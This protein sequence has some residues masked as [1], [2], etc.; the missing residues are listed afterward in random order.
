M[1]SVHHA[2]G[3]RVATEDGVYTPSVLAALTHNATDVS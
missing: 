1:L 3:K 2:A